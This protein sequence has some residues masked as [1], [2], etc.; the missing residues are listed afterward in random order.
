MHKTKI[1][2]VEDEIIIANN[3][4]E[5]LE[6]IGY[7]VVDIAPTAT[8]AIFSFAKHD[9]DLVLMDIKLKEKE[10]GIDVA[11]KIRKISKVPIIFLTANGDEKTINAALETGPYG[12]ILKPVREKELVINIE[13]ALKKY[14]LTNSEQA[15]SVEQQQLVKLHELGLVAGSLIHDLISPLQSLQFAM[16]KI[17]GG[18]KNL[19]GK[20]DYAIGMVEM[21]R[22]K[23]NGIN[24][25]ADLE[26]VS[27]QEVVNESVR[28]LDHKLKAGNISLRLGELELEVRCHRY[29]LMQIM[30]NL[31]RNSIDALKDL[32]EKWISVEAETLGGVKLVKVTDS[33]QGIEPELREKIFS[34]FFTTKDPAKGTGLGLFLS[35]KIM[36]QMGGDLR[37]NSESPNTQFQL[38]F[39][40][41]SVGH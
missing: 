35:Q 29:Q 27:L 20:I 33:G 40:A 25:E 4:A 3:I 34:I 28:L 31:L 38:V 5:I 22:A 23:L 10:T 36:N 21:Y 26:M 1:L 18:D 12:Y 14:E 11:K 19:M 41:G 32:P 30:T 17:V 8:K 9:P 6:G 7:E 37:Y 24:R 2:I 39:A 15:V 13:L 16:E